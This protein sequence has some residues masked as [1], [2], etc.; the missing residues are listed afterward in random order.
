MYLGGETRMK[1]ARKSSLL[2]PI[3]FFLFRC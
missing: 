2:T 3:D 1:R